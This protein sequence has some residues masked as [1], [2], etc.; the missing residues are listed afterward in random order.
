MHIHSHQ[1]FLTGNS[2]H[3]VLP[4]T[5]RSVGG[6]FH[7]QK[8]AFVANLGVIGDRVERNMVGRMR[9]GEGWAAWAPGHN[10]GWDNNG[11][12][13][14]GHWHKTFGHIAKQVDKSLHKFSLM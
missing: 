2:V 1:I 12:Q 10:S 14:G 7:N 3:V 4:A 8:A 13:S 5:S 6:V 11:S 9:H